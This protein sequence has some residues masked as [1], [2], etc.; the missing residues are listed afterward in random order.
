MIHHTELINHI[1]LSIIFLIFPF[2]NLYNIN[3]SQSVYDEKWCGKWLQMQEYP[4][5]ILIYQYNQKPVVLSVTCVLQELSLGYHCSVTHVYVWISNATNR[6][7]HM[8]SKFILVQ[9]LSNVFSILTVL[10]VVVEDYS[11]EVWSKWYFSYVMHNFFVMT[12][13][14]V[15]VIL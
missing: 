1:W 6:G 8:N 12:R 11:I 5:T 7:Y 4:L 10:Q 13:I 3:I 2:H 15:T 14:V 9:Y